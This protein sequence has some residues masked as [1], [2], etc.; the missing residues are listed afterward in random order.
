MDCGLVEHPAV[1]YR[2]PCTLENNTLIVSVS[3]EHCSSLRGQLEDLNVPVVDM[4]VPMV[5][6]WRPNR[7]DIPPATQAADAGPSE[8]VQRSLLSDTE[9]SQKLK[10]KMKDEPYTTDEE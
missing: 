6:M 9:E 8:P 3:V 4:Q 5:D 2:I 1:R 7:A 10:G